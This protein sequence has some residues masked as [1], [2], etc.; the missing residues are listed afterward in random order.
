M[1]VVNTDNLK[2]IL[3]KVEVIE[4]KKINL[5]KDAVRSYLEIQKE[6]LDET[7]RNN[8]FRRASLDSLN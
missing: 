3:T 4:T 8:P 6:S 2:S 7:L 1:V 5:M